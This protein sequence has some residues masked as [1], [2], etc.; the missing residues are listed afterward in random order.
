MFGAESSNGVRGY[1]SEKRAL[2]RCEP[3]PASPL[4]FPAEETAGTKALGRNRG[5]EGRR[6]S[7]QRQLLKGLPAGD[8]VCRM[9]HAA[10]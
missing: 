8:K 9:P 4:D 10:A 7:L 6:S 1:A 5:N 2:K 3:E